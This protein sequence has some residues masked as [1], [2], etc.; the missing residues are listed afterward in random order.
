MVL[1][2]DGVAEAFSVLMAAYAVERI[3]LAVEIKAGFRVIVEI[4]HAES[5][6]YLVLNLVV[7]YE[8]RRRGV[9]IGIVYAVPEM[10]ILN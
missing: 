7:I 9:E 8:L 6:S 1:F 2:R 4:P 10:C 5:C 3:S